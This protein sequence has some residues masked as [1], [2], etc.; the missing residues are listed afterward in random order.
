VRNIAITG[1]MPLPP[2]IKRTRSGRS[3][4]NTN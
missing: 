2:L 4:G 1:V 3:A